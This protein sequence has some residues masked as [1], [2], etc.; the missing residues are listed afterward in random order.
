MPRKV[1]GTLRAAGD[2]VT[3][4]SHGQATVTIGLN[5]WF[6][7]EVEVCGQPG[8]PASLS[9]LP[10]LLVDAETGPLG[11]GFIRASGGRFDRFLTAQAAFGDVI[12]R[13]RPGFTG[14][15]A[16]NLGALTESLVTVIA[17]PITDSLE[18]AQR[19]GRAFSVGT[20]TQQAAAGSH[21]NFVFMNP[22]NSGVQAHIVTRRFAADTPSGDTPLE[23]SL[24]VNPPALSP[25][26]TVPANNLITGGRPSVME[27]A[28][29]VAAQ[30]LNN[31]VIG[32]FYGT[33]GA[34]T[35]VSTKR[36]V[37]PG[38]SFGYTTEGSGSALT[39][40]EARIANNLIWYEEPIR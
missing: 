35:I 24:V 3:L 13:A 28:Y 5:G 23:F 7:G 19:A 2:V 27:F 12:V 6:D 25:G 4:Y 11:K 26:T 39:S 1:T 36:I 22:A 31:R 17:A 14:D 33:G 38:E 32:S 30:N 20:G 8:G 10:L 29:E 40:N 16:V 21:L 15:L 37:G 9:E 34:S 18:Q